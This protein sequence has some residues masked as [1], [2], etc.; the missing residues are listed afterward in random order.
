MISHRKFYIERVGHNSS[1][2]KTLDHLP[3]C[4]TPSISCFR[5]DLTILFFALLSF[6]VAS[7]SIKHPGT[8]C[9]IRVKRSQ[10]GSHKSRISLSGNVD[11]IGNTD[12]AT[13]IYFYIY[14]A[15]HKR[16]VVEHRPI[17]Y[18][19]VAQ[20]FSFAFFSCF[21][22]NHLPTHSYSFLQFLDTL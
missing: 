4:P 10:Q 2:A 3:S 12:Y 1:V 15:H 19:L 21:C 22:P 8:A 6:S 20:L 7:H 14:L 16:H 9:L 17:S 11:A 13:V 18:T 5:Q